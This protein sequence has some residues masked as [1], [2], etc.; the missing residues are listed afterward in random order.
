MKNPTHRPEKK[1]KKI[2]YQV[3][4]P[5]DCLIDWGLVDTDKCTHQTIMR[6]EKVSGGETIA[7]PYRCTACGKE[8][9]SQRS[10]EL[11]KDF[12]AVTKLQEKK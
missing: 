6:Y 4:D 1:E 10:Y 5:F 11:P 2:E 7:T 3:L 12:D 8:F 9:N